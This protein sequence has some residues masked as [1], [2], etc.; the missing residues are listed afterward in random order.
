MSYVYV[1]SEP[2]LYTVG[3]TDPVT[4][5]W[6]PDSDHATR[7]AAAERV[8]Y[9]HGGLVSKPY[10]LVTVYGGVPD[11]AINDQKVEVDILDFDNLESTGAEDANLSDREWEFLRKNNPDLYDFFAPSRAKEE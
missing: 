10:V 4:G 8:R 5:R 7:E 1:Q 11:I 9:L 2:N 6:H 3:H